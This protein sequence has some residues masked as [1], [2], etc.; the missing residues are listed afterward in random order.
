MTLI[1][2]DPQ[3]SLAVTL[4]N[5]GNAGPWITRGGFAQAAGDFDPAGDFPHIPQRLRILFPGDDSARADTFRD[6]NRIHAA[7]VATSQPGHR[8]YRELDLRPRLEAGTPT[9][10]QTRYSIVSAAH[11]PGMDPGHYAGD[12]IPVEVEIQFLKEPSWSPL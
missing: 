5:A 3:A 8:F 9:E 10:G 7:A 12:G 4:E 11:I 2:R 6:I 1:L